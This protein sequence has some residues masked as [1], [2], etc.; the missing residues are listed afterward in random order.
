MA[1]GRP[2][3]RIRGDAGAVHLRM[4]VAVIDVLEV[5]P[6]SAVL[7]PTGNSKVRLSPG[8]RRNPS[9]AGDKIGPWA[10]RLRRRT[11]AGDVGMCLGDDHIRD[12]THGHMNRV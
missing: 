2:G 1:R 3:H 10:R 12:P 6:E 11:G 9:P 5:P 8:W 7:D 4:T